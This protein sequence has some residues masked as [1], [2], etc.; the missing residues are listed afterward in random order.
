M[1]FYQKI[2]INIKNEINLIESLTEFKYGIIHGDPVFT[3]IFKITGI[4]LFI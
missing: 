4:K 1:E 2:G 3:N